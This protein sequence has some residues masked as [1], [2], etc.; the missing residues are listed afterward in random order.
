M[1]QVA[2]AAPDGHNLLLTGDSLITIGA[3]QA[4]AG[5]D[6]RTSFAPVTLAV[7]AAQ[8]LVTH[9]GTG[10]NTVAEYV[11]HVRRNPGRLN[12][13]LPGW[14]GIAHLVNE[15]LN[16]QLGLRVE[17]IPY[18]GGA[19][20]AL[21][22]MARQ[23][24][25]II[26]TLPAVTEQVREGRLVGLAVS[27]AQRDP[28]LPQVP[29]LAETVAPGFDVE[30]FQGILAPAGTSPAVVAELHAGIA[31]ALAQPTVRARLTELGYAIVAAPP[32]RFAERIAVLGERFGTVI[33]EAGITPR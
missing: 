27:T 19:P 6:A 15:M 31:A 24:D 20:A 32:A 7:R 11:A 12:M 23:V 14:G 9:P 5:Y 16:R 1:Q 26:I 2:R 29:S 22:L 21:D 4:E 28:A 33:R 18:R 3:M 13:G 25:A 8:L 30:S 10:I 17:Y